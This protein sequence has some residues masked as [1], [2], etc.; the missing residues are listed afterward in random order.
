MKTELNQ[1]S[2]PNDP[3]AIKG[4]ERIQTHISTVYLTQ[5][6]VYKFRKAVKFPFLDFETVE[7][8]NGDCEREISLN[9]RLAKDVYLGLAA[10]DP[11]HDPPVVGPTTEKILD[12]EQ[13]HCVVMRRLP[14][15]RDAL[16]LLEKNTLTKNQMQAA[17]TLIARFH[18]DNRLAA[19]QE[20][21]AE[22][23]LARCVDPARA[24]VDMLSDCI[25]NPEESAALNE[26]G[27]AIDNFASSHAE[28]FEARRL[29]GRAVDGHGDLHLQHIWFTG[30]DSPRIIDCIEFNSTLR[31]I[32]SASDIAFL[33]M[34]L[35]YRQREDLAHAFLSRYCAISDD[36]PLFPVL[37]YFISYR[38]AV[39]A[40]VAALA[41]QDS[42]LA[43]D[44]REFAARS[45]DR[46]LHF[47]CHA[48]TQRRPGWVIAT[49]GLIGSGKS[50]LAEEL[51][52]Q[53]NALILSSDRLRK[54][55]N[56]TDRYTQTAK[57]AVYE[58]LLQRAQLIL[59]SGRN[60]IL[61][62]SFSEFRIRRQLRDWANVGH[63]PV[64]LLETTCDP[65]VTKKRLTERKLRD[66]D[67]S[68]AGAELYESFAAHYEPRD[69]WPKELHPQIQMDRE[70]W[71]EQAATALTL[72]RAWRKERYETT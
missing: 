13:E 20:I 29:E 55:Q 17:A 30:A 24:N 70:D 38:A 23:W 66:D 57:D 40:K 43:A 44:Q 18:R 7:A 5:A 49:S 45:A 36:Y 11:A 52:D 42:D 3:Q 31:Q 71:R 64:L 19:S 34:D 72:F 35:S 60:V 61:D 4:I 39:R 41:A 47:A 67:A 22:A 21:S 68:D 6:C 56:V 59:D 15:G 1:N 54:H 2:F 25:E 16:S 46:H 8:R 28:I 37:D 10:L 9:R 33:V 26:L 65:T 62:A 32:D 63:N 48:L 27:Q 53:S 50:T 51:A 58:G 14:E 69:E 12:P